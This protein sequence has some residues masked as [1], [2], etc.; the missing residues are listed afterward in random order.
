MANKS[1]LF[2]FII[3]AFAGL[4]FVLP[5]HA[6]PEKM[7]S[8]SGIMKKVFDLKGKATIGTGTLTAKDGNTLTV[9]KDGK[10]YSV[11]VDS[12]TQLRRKFWGKATLDEMQIGDT[13]NVM[14]KWTDETKTAVLAK[15]IRDVSIQKRNGVFVGTV[16]SL[17]SNGWMMDTIKRGSQTVTVSSTTRF[18][19]RK[20]VSIA[21]SDILVGH[22]VRV[23]GLWNSQANTITEVTHVKDFSLPPVSKPSK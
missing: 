3:T 18:V 12:N 9:S 1:K 10:S 17:T 5:V 20:G 23:K 15:M 21:Q 16:N 2:I 19:N 4:L 13:L 14:G 22:K 11:L 6:I 7:G 8:K